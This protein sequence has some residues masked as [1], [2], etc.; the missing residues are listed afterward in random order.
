M[1]KPTKLFIALI[2]NI[3]YYTRKI[4][5]KMKIVYLICSLLMVVAISHSFS[6]HPVLASLISFGIGI[7]YMK[8]KDK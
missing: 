2:M 3:E 6:P 5:T 1:K 4:M 7:G 8:T